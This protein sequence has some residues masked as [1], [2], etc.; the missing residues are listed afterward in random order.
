MGQTAEELRGQLATQ[1]TE[2]SRDLD[3]IGDRVSPHRMVERKQA[4]VRQRF[5][6]FKE[7]VMGSA[8][9]SVD[10]VRDAGA[11]AATTLTDS[12]SSV[13]HTTRHAAEGNPLA[14]GLI[15]FGAG[16]VAAT[17]FPASRKE[18]ELAERAQPMLEKAASEAVPAARH[19]VEELKPAA[20]EAVADLRES[21]MDAASSVKD[22]AVEAASDTK[23]ATQQMLSRPAEPES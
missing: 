8:E 23:R 3:A 2:I 4:A 10:A 19:L 1:R 13:A 12:A 9:S 6:D 18:R 17:V 22:Q 5:S 7:N 14:V 21:A 15:A 20:Q 11:S 16:L